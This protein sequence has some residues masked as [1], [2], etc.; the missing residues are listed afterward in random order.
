MA[1]NIFKRNRTLHSG[2]RLTY[3]CTVYASDAVAA[4]RQYCGKS[5]DNNLVAMKSDWQGN[6]RYK[7]A[8]NLNF[9]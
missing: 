6:G 7:I 5:Y 9:A 3:V 8:G 2:T 1:Y 4:M